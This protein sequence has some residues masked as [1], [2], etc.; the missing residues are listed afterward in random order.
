MISQSTLILLLLF[1][2]SVQISLSMPLKNVSESKTL[3]GGLLTVS[4]YTRR[5]RANRDCVHNTLCDYNTWLDWISPGSVLSGPSGP[6]KSVGQEFTESFGLF[7]SSQIT[8]RVQSIEPGKGL[9]LLTSN[10]QGTFGWDA[11]SIDFTVDPEPESPSSSS[12]LT[13]RYSWIVE[14]PVISFLEKALVRKSMLDDNEKALDRLA[15]LCERRS[16]R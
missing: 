13:Y 11:I 7:S 9:Q 3:S 16:Q 2:S 12:I 8:W 14:N 6:L 15:E 5:I 10:K 1:A 4:E